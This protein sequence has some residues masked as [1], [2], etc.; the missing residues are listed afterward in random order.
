MGSER[1]DSL[2]AIVDIGEAML[3]CGADVHTVEETLVRL[4]RAYGAIRM[5]VLVITVEIVATAVFPPDDELTLSRR[6][7][8]DGSSDFSKLESLVS[9]CRECYDR[10]LAPAEL[11]RRCASIS[12]ASVSARALYAGGAL[13]SAGFAVFFGGGF[14]DGLM[15]A[16][17][18]IAAC[19]LIRHFKPIAPN[20][21]IFNFVT[22]LALGLLICAASGAIPQMDV[23]MVIVGVIMLLIPGVAMTN[24]TRDILSGDTI[25][26]VMRFVE[27]LLWALA[28]A[29]GFMVA[30]FAM[31]AIGLGLASG[32]EESYPP[33]L[34]AAVT[35]IASLGFALLFN[36]SARHVLSASIGGVLAWA[37]FGAVG[38]LGGNVLVSSLVASTVAAVYAEVLATWLKVPS[39]AFFIIAVIPLV[40]GRY[41]YYAMYSAV[42]AAWDSFASYGATTLMYSA[43]IAAGICLVAAF[44]Q[45]SHGIKAKAC[46]RARLR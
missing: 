10:P 13:A 42:N 41:L 34:M 17:F 30:L 22:S 46:K 5:N 21:I 36:V 14:L 35:F 19:A 23:G 31:G 32:S 7:L 40:P 33:A 38:V 24:A 9:L 15:S 4:G 28:L 18:S 16:A 39:S 25:S 1:T 37:V 29:L 43:G 8:A 11:K 44:V 12:E 26:G 3:E 2:S 20:V 27:S 6:I 45:I